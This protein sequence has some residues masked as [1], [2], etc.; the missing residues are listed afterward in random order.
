MGNLRPKVFTWGTFDNLHDGHKEF[1]KRLSLLGILYVIVIPSEKK[2]ENSGYRP[3]KDTET[4]K[5]DLLYFG[6]VENDNLIEEVFIDSYSEGLKS[7]LEIRPQI[8]CL[9]YDQNLI[10]DKYLIEFARN[11]ELNI[12]FFRMITA[13]GNGVH[14]SSLRN[15]QIAKEG[16]ADM[17]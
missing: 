9:G 5:N 3:I 15:Q 17:T 1:L 2:I 11:H 16:T 12:T 8:F 6:R 10:W 4:R 14:T 13:N 7:L